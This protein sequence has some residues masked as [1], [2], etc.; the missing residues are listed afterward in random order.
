MNIN[1]YSIVSKDSGIFVINEKFFAK[2]FEIRGKEG[3]WALDQR[4]SKIRA[5]GKELSEGR[6][7]EKCNKKMRPW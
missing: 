6:K 1:L 3:G 5:D 4:L 2:F 7:K